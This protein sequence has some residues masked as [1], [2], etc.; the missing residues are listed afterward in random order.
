MEA[1]ACMQGVEIIDF[2]VVEVAIEFEECCF[3][4][5]GPSFSSIDQVNLDRELVI[6]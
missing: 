5:L 3:A 2:L 1:P 6:V 4:S